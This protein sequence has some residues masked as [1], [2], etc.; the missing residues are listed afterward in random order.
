MSSCH[1]CPADATHYP[2]LVFSHDGRG[3]MRVV[4]DKPVCGE[5]QA[6]IAELYASPKHLRDAADAYEA[7]LGVAL[8]PERTRVVFLPLAHPE[9]VKFRRYLSASH[10]EQVEQ[11]RGE[12]FAA[13]KRAGG[14]PVEVLP[15]REIVDM[16][17]DVAMRPQ[18]A[19]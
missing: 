2:Q 17:L 9:V 11:K 15:E 3:A 1:R 16:V 18:K 12:C 7:S 13:A 10:A 4:Y 14:I 8:R 19:G 5:H 6:P